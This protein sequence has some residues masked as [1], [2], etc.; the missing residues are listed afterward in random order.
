MNTL[1]GN[2]RLEWGEGANK[3]GIRTM[4]GRKGRRLAGGIRVKVSRSIGP[5]LT[6]FNSVTLLRFLQTCARVFSRRVV[7]ESK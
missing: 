1:K 2:N 4:A 5:A 3:L 6:D 7:M